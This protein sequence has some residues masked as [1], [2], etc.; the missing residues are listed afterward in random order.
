MTLQEF[1]KTVVKT[2][3]Y[4]K[5]YYYLISIAA[6]GGSIYLFY[7]IGTNPLKYKSR[8]SYEIALMAYSLLFLL[9]CYAIYLI[10]NRY[11]VLTVDN[12][13]PVDKKK[14]IISKLLNKLDISLADTR[15]T[16][17]SFRYQRKWWTSDYDVYLFVDN[18]KFYIC[19]LGTAHAY[20]ASGYID[21]GGTERLRR[22]IVSV[23][24][25]LTGDE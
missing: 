11:K 15:D 12:S 25:S 14:D 7:D 5:Y 22:K 23:I 9:G 10:P 6:I 13:L 21:F 20:P 19:V 17:Y 24:K 2:N 16:F 4:D 8:H 1:Q 18:E 3:W